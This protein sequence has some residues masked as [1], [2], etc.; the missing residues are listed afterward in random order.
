MAARDTDG[1]PTGLGPAPAAAPPDPYWTHLWAACP[2]IHPGLCTDAG[3][4]LPW[5]PLPL[6]SPAQRFPFWP[7]P[8]PPPLTGIRIMTQMGRGWERLL[9]HCYLIWGPGHP[10]LDWARCSPSLG[11][12]QLTPSPGHFWDP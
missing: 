5:V 8:L 6:H 10:W 11:L 4:W 1:V 12:L 2:G 3:P 7:L 9:P